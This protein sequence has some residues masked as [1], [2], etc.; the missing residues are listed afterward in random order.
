M[1]AFAAPAFLW[2]SLA[3]ALPVVVHLLRRP[4]GA[5]VPV[6]GI[7]FFEAS[8]PRETGAE[9]LRR[10]VLLAA[11]ALA[12]LLIAVLFAQPRWLGG[13]S[14]EAAA[15][16]G[17]AL[18][19][20]AGRSLLVLVD[21]SGSTAQRDARGVVAAEAIA[22]AADRALAGLT[23]G[24][25]AA[26]AV[27]VGAGVEPVLPEFTTNL[28]VLRERLAVRLAAERGAEGVADWRG[29]FVRGA[30]LAQRAAG[31]GGPAAGR[32]RVAVVTDA[33][34]EDWAPLAAELAGAGAGVPAVTVVPALAAAMPNARLAVAEVVPPVGRSRRRCG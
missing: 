22:D 27:V 33:Q 8:R 6:P 10:Y 15:A 1:I 9:R 26:A 34:A 13:P 12:I 11:R 21:F 14:R 20:A 4:A 2:A 31:S 25:D 19:D 32:V 5:A 23:P 30:A 24:L 17:E 29:A 3:A 16:G 7:R 28:A 18:A